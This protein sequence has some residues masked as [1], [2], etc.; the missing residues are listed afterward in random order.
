[1]K[2]SILAEKF[3]VLNRHPVFERFCGLRQIAS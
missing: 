2:I 3:F 1:M